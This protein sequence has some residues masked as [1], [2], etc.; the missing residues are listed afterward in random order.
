MA[1]PSTIAPL[2]WLRANLFSSVGNS[3]LTV[4]VV[5]LLAWL[6]PKALGWLV[7]NAVWG[8][9]PLSACEAARGTGACWAV[10]WEKFR[11]M[12]FG[13]YPYAEQW[14][15]GLAIVTL[16]SLLV[17]STWRFLW[18]LW[19]VLIW[20]VGIALT[21]W[22][23][24]GGLG[25][26]PVRTEQ[27]GG[28]PVTLILAIFGIGLAFPLG[29]LLALGRRSQ[30]P[31]VRAL[32]VIYIEV[33]R[34]VPLITVLFMASVMFA[35]FLPEGVRIDQLLRAQVAIILFVAAYLA[36]AVRGGLQA[37]PKGQYEAAEALGLPYWKKMG[38]VILPQALRVSIP[39]IVNSFISLFKDTSL[40]VIIAI[41]DFA[42]AVKK[43]VETDYTWKKYFIEAFL[44]SILIYW[45]YCF[46]MSR[47]SQRLERELSHTH[48]R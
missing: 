31:I 7:F 4:L 5:A 44:F 18:N 16:T 29:V 45:I 14:R 35:L 36:E 24:G 43:S 6:V 34:G 33:V 37:V 39:P 26:T 28:L 25:L 19:L 3:I 9:Q 47:Y 20:V 8:G 46:A 40:V 17:V 10:V 11:F 23:M 15:G 13:T 27:W 2:R 48:S 32:S 12:F 41:Y 38:L 21:F 30:L 1:A 42:Y 22:L